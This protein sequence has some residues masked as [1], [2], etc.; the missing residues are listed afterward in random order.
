MRVGGEHEEDNARDPADREAER[1]RGITVLRCERAR[2]QRGDQLC[3]SG[4]HQPGKRLGGHVGGR[5]RQS[6]GDQLAPEVGEH[7]RHHCRRDRNGEEGDGIGT[8][9]GAEPPLR[10]GT[11]EVGH[12]HHAEGLGT[13]HEDQIDPVGGHEAIGLVVPAELVREKGTGHRGGKAQSHI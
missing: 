11:G 7:S 8:E 9:L 10:L 13:E 12:D 1:G 3:E 4:G 2:R 5:L 6:P